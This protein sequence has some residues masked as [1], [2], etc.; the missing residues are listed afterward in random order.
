MSVD[1]TYVRSLNYAGLPTAFSLST[2]IS[3][4]A[5]VPF[6]VTLAAAK[7][8]TLT[9]RTDDNTGTLTMSASHG[10]TTGARLDLYWT[11]GSRRGMTVG[12]VS[13]NSVP[14]DGGSGDVLPSAAASITAQ[15]PTEQAVV[16]TGDDII[17]LAAR[18]PLGGTIVYADSGDVELAY[19]VLT[20]TLTTYVWVEADGGTNPLAGDALAKVFL[21]Q[22]SSAAT[23]TASGL[24]QYD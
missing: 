24:V 5:A 2:T 23:S 9:T 16:V 18:L 13:V 21:S 3:S 7:T 1:S 17:A 15:V 6:S 12:T 22:G 4:E 8:G 14:I 10:I 11:G 19:A 20:S